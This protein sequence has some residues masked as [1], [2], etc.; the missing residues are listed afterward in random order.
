MTGER[1]RLFVW[2]CDEC[3]YW[4]KDESTGVHTAN[5]P[6]DP[7]GPMLR[8]ALRRAWFEEVASSDKAA[9]GSGE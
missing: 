9:F 5:N 2:F 8:H 4:R 1:P 3:G 7:G 6:A